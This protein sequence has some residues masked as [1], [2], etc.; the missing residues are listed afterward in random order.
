MESRRAV[1]LIDLIIVLTGVLLAPVCARWLRLPVSGVLAVVVG[2]LLS[3]WRLAAH[4]E[5]WRTLGLCQPS[6]WVRTTLAAMALYLIV[7]AGAIGIIAPIARALHWP[8][9]ELSR[10]A[11]IRG[12]PDN[13]A[14]MLLV[15]WGSA[16][17]GEELLFR[18]FLLGRIERVLGARSAATASAVVAQATIFAV[19]HSYLGTRGIATAMLI[20]L[21]Y[22]TWYVLRGRNLW[23][24]VLAHGLTDTVSLFA[25][26]SGL[27]R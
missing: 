14:V 2:V 7:A 25:I 27:L 23:P 24:L 10:Y 19:A 8:G 12:D 16:A 26:Y 11:G 17:F 13:L 20:G 4:S 22:G 18:G 21:I 15:A 9:L 6:S 3:S 1:A 5:Q